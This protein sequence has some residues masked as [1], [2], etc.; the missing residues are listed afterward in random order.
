MTGRPKVDRPEW[1]GSRRIW[2]SS[3]SH[4]VTSS[5]TWRRSRARAHLEGFGVPGEV[6][7]ARKCL[8]ALPHESRAPNPWAHAAVSL[9]GVDVLPHI[10][11]SVVDV[12]DVLDVDEL[13]TAGSR[14][15]IVQ[16]TRSVGRLR[17]LRHCSTWLFGLR[18]RGTEE[19]TEVS[20]K[21]RHGGGVSRGDSWN[22]GLVMYIRASQ[23]GTWVHTGR[24]G[25]EA[26][27][28]ADT[29]GVGV[30]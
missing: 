10:G 21:L 30:V 23:L 28:F 14:T 4:S 7:S 3:R 25:S 20:C 22:Q 2:C 15:R 6:G 13:N 1:R 12:V 5:L 27:G 26:Q 19:T 24:G 11:C 17:V 16:V 8:E 9:M 29:V 18:S